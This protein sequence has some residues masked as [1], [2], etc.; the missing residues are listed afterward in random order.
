[1]KINAKI[2]HPTKEIVLNSKEIEA[3]NAEIL[4]QDGSSLIVS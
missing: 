4:T 2:T 3:Q 1:M